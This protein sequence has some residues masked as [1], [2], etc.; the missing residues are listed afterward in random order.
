MENNL[1]IYEKLIIGTSSWAFKQL[2]SFH[3][4]ACIHFKLLHLRSNQAF[5]DLSLCKAKIKLNN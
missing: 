1:F 2:K 4:G 3:S 5:L